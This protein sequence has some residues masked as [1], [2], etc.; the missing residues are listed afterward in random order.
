LL[1]TEFVSLPVGLIVCGNA[2][3]PTWDAGSTRDGCTIP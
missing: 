1:A 3:G 2:T